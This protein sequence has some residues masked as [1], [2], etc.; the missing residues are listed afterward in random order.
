ME[1]QTK[2]YVASRFEGNP[3]LKPIPEHSWESKLVF[4]PAM[5]ELG[6]RVHFLYRAMG[7]DMVSR[8]G[9]ASSLDGQHIDERLD[10]PVFEP[11]NPSEI[12]GVEDPRVTIVEDRCYMTYT[13]YAQTAQI[14]ITSIKSRDLMA[15]NWDWEE[16]IYPFPNITNKNSAL[17]PVKIGGK[18]VL[19]HRID[20]N[21]C[22][23][24]SDD[25]Q[26]WNNSKIVMTPR[27]NSWDCLRVGIAGP[28]IELDEGWLQIY[29]GVDQNRV[30]RLG[31]LLLEK[32]NP[33]KILY[34]SLEPIFEPQTDYECNGFIPNVVFSCG[35]I[36]RGNDILI[37]YGAADT[38]VSVSKLS[39]EEI[40]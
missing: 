22:I 15:K 2:R 24:Y 39:L 34:R 16:R 31:A 12:R 19:F 21:L 26:N 40:C 10:Y 32:G 30:Y 8:L 33:E 6:G 20:P 1:Y 38:V 37:S 18:S 9:Y 3:I 25:M 28:P 23:A 35:A 14:G 11:K 27:E 36:R 17:F 29:H 7:N 5:F 13:A 4:N